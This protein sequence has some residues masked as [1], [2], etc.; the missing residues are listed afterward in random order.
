MKK[1]LFKIDSQTVTVTAS[2]KESAINKLVEGGFIE[3]NKIPV[4]VESWPVPW[5]TG[6]EGKLNT[7]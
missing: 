6:P 5:P 7:P 3:W 4:L 2:T 1:Y